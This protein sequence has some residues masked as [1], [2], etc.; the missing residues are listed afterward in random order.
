MSCNI[1]ERNRSERGGV[2]VR[3]GLFQIGVAPVRIDV[4]TA[5]D[6]VDFDEAW[7]ER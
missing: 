2:S 7:P 4:I 3:G 1:V 5:S 6:V